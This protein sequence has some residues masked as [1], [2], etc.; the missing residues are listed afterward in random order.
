VTITIAE[1]S[2]TPV[3]FLED[4]NLTFYWHDQSPD[5]SDL[6]PLRSGLTT[7][8][9]AVSR[10]GHEIGYVKASYITQESLDRLYPRTLPYLD[11]IRG[12][13]I[14]YDWDHDLTPEKI[15]ERAHR[16]GPMGWKGAPPC[17]DPSGPEYEAGISALEKP[18]LKDFKLWQAW[19]RIPFVAYSQVLDTRGLERKGIPGPSLRGTGLGTR[20]YELAARRLAEDGRVLAASGLQTPEAQAVW[21]RMTAAGYPI[22]T[23]TT[24]HRP[25]MKRSRLVLDY[26]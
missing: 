23:D 1:P 6:G 11:M 12:W 7:S 25:G 21:A 14:G 20:L 10:D 5:K 18:Y 4:G 26:T 3:V 16:Y 24:P 9:M 22:R 17:P 2:T 13:S 19:T 15:W 8:K